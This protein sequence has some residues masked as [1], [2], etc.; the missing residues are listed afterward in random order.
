[1]RKAEGRRPPRGSR[2]SN[3]NGDVKHGAGLRRF[4]RRPARNTVEKSP[5]EVRLISVAASHRLQHGEI[6]R[7]HRVFGERL[8]HLVPALLRPE[9][10]EVRAG[11]P[12]VPDRVVVDAKPEDL[13]ARGNL[14][15][16]LQLVVELPVE[17]ELRHVE[18]RLL[19]AVGIHDHPLQALAAQMHV[20]RHRVERD[21]FGHRGDAG[22][23]PVLRVGRDV[24]RAAV[25]P[26]AAGSALYSTS[27]PSAR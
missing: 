23:T 9:H 3:R 6:L 8:V 27:R 13:A 18:D 11:V 22:E 15:R 24:R 10:L 25:A 7:V 26:R 14:Q 1:M 20:R 2:R 19:G 12:L 21:V 4:G 17:V 16:L 5:P